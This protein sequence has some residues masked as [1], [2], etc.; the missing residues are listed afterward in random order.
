MIENNLELNN[1]LTLLCLRFHYIYTI[2]SYL[3]IKL[4][5]NYYDLLQK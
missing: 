1:Y 5:I 4:Q 2:K 3:Q